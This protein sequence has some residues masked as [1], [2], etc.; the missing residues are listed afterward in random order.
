ML[1]CSINLQKGNADLPVNYRLFSLLNSVCR[2]GT[3]TIRN[4]MQDI[5]EEHLCD[6]QS[7]FS[8]SRSTSQAI[9][10]T[11]RLQDI[12]EQEGANMMIT[13]LDW[14][15]AFDKVQHCRSWIALCTQG[16]HDTFVEV[17]KD[18]YTE[19]CFSVE[20]EY[21]TSTAKLQSAGRRQGC[22]LSP[23]LFV[24]LMSVV[25]RDVALNLDT[26]YQRRNP[27]NCLSKE[28]IMPTM[29]F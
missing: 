12:S 16:I 11:R 13:F 21:G 5:V 22:S 2:I 23:Y 17:L 1:F 26:A 18:C 19:A 10:R 20:D 15:K 27:T 24:L 29:L 14:D 6:A 25:D 8:P 7:G 4:R 28:F 3:I 9:Y